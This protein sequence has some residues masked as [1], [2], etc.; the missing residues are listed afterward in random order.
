MNWKNFAL[1]ILRCQ[2][3]RILVMGRH[4]SSRI[5]EGAK[6]LGEVQKKLE[7]LHNSQS[8]KFNSTLEEFETLGEKLDSQTENSG[9]KLDRLIDMVNENESSLDEVV[10]EL[11]GVHKKL[12][13]IMK[14][15][16]LTDEPRK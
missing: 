10:D 13:L 12:N 8:R 14:H 11:M 4:D 15:L 3:K 7:V 2:K 16:G 1:P 9:K 5:Y 6:S